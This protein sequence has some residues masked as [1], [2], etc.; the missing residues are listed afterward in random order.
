VTTLDWAVLAAWLAFIV[1]YGVWRGGRSRDIRGFV[2]ADKDMRWPTVAL[3]IMATQASAIT[4][5]STPGQAYVDGVRFVQ[6]YLGLPLAMIVLAITAVPLYHRLTVYTA[7]EF[8][9]Q[10]CDLKTRTLAASLFLVQRG[11]AAGLTIYAPALILSVILGWDVHVTVVLIGGLV[12]IYTTSGGTRAVSRTHVLQAAIILLGL[13]ATFAVLVA[14]LPRD[15]SLLDA[16][17]VGGAAGRL[18]AIDTSL[19]LTSRYTLWSGLLGG[20]FLALSYFGT[21]QSQVQRYLSGRS[22]AESRTGLL[23]NGLFKVPLQLAILLLGVAV[24]AFDH[25]ARPPIFFDPVA[26][27]KAKASAHG[28]E[29][30]ALEQRWANALAAREQ[31]A[32][33]FARA[34][35]AGDESEQRRARASLHAAEANA[36][37]LH[38]QAVALIA[39]ADPRSNPNDTNYV[40]LS[41]VVRHL[42][43]GLLGLMLAAVFAAAMN[44]SS[45]ELN[46]L[47]ATTTVDVY[48]RFLAP[49]GSERRAVFVSRAATVFWGGF[50]VFFAEAIHRMGSLV[51]AVNVLGSLFYGTILGIFVVAFY[52]RGMSGTTVFSAA[53]VAEAAVLACFAFTPVSF[54][55]YNVVG[56]LGVVILAL[57][58]NPLLAARARSKARNA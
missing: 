27:Q 25:F 12:V 4:F 29:L 51:E 17:R 1:A 16:A 56:C 10:R 38:Q 49:H 24:F 2:L 47:A 35:H 57:A 36:G 22:V 28:D 58:I 31:S 40:F 43:T 32:R 45:A 20:F 23:F 30:G 33:E 44:S 6:F 3:S 55:W 7:Y 14:S 8:L 11:L 34:M 19:N 5:L 46:A 15:I 37:T 13:A 26:L 39:A 42:P 53:I 54:L 21:D 52:G 18:R 9:E 41:F 50:A 48:R